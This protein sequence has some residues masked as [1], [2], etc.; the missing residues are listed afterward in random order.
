[1]G[2]VVHMQVVKFAIAFDISH[3]NRYTKRW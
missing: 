1:V 3:D 2:S